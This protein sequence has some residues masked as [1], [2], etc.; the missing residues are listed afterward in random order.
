MGSNIFNKAL[1]KPVW[2]LGN[3]A[4]IAKTLFQQINKSPATLQKELDPLN[5]QVDTTGDIK[6]DSRLKLTEKI[7]RDRYWGT[8]HWDS[9]G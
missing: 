8:V 3:G 2:M 4:G 6:V 7:L 5:T 9:C 1:G